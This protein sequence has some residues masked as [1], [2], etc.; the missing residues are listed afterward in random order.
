MTFADAIQ[1]RIAALDHDD[2]A[3][4]IVDLRGN[5]GGNMWPMIAGVGPI[6]GEGIL[7]YFVDPV[8]VESVWEYPTGASFL[9]GAQYARV[10]TPYI[11]R[12][13]NPR[14][15]VLT[16]NGVASSGEAVAI[17][18]RQRPNT[19]SFGTA[20]CGLSTSNRGYPLSD[21]AVLYLTT[22]VMAD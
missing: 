2:L 19:R 16:N 10:T 14:V 7:G 8:G 21:G 18:F 22:S 6:V 5:G 3:G 4:W 12:R 17:A 15:A 20:T 9:D 11:L 13:Q 1:R